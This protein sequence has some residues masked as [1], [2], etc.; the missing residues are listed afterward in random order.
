MLKV[1]N[2][3]G[4]NRAPQAAMMQQ[5]LS[6]ALTTDSPG[7]QGFTTRHFF[8]PLAVPTAPSLVQFIRFTL[9]GAPG[10]DTGVGSMFV[11]PAAAGAPTANVNLNARSLVPVT[12]NKG[13]TNVLVPMGTQFV[14]D[15][16]QFLWDKTSWLCATFFIVGGT[17]GHLAVAGGLG[18]QSSY[19]YK[20]ANEAGNVTVDA[21][22][23]TAATSALN[24]LAL[25][26]AIAMGMG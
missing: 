9:Q 23:Y 22:T 16:V 3:R 2:L 8:G 17:S 4:F 21:T 20:N 26:T 5:V 6:Y 7:W 14:S 10:S 15:P 12:F 25:V 19:F 13:Q 24:Q 11:G 1:S 18:G